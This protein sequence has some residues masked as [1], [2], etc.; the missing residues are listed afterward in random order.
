MIWKEAKA[1][2]AETILE[3]CKNEEYLIAGFDSEVGEIAGKLKKAI[4][5]DFPVEQL[6]D[7]LKYEIGDVCWYLGMIDMFLVLPD[8]TCLSDYD[9]ELEHFPVNGVEKIETKMSAFNLY[10]KIQQESNRIFSDTAT[11]T[12]SEIFAIFNLLAALAGR[13]DLTIGE[14]IEAV[15]EKLSGR[16]KIGTIQGDGDEVNR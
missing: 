1:K 12:K 7:K 15:I 11:M 9:L 5:G 4:R 10:R 6:K 3:E 2:F 14:C 8:L 16:K 13:C